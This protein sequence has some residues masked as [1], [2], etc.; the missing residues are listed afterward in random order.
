MTVLKADSMK[1]S[2]F[3]IVYTISMVV[4][5][6]AQ[7]TDITKFIFFIKTALF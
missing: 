7:T 1:S 2:Y 3:K 5:F 4:L 6:I